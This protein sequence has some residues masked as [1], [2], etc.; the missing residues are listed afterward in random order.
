MI[1]DN[2]L[3]TTFGSLSYGLFYILYWL[4]VFIPRLAVSIRRLHDVGKSGWMPL[5]NLI[6]IID[7]IW[8]FVLMIIDSDPGENKY[9]PNPKVNV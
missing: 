4:G 2:L 7:W 1:I 9:G 3:G 8:L 6:P 5:I